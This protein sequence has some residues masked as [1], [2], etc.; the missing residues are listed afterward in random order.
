MNFYFVMLLVIALITSI[1]IFVGV[2]K[3]YIRKSAMSVPAILL[4]LGIVFTF[5]W[6][7]KTSHCGVFFVT[8]PS[9]MVV[10]SNL[11]FAL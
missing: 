3:E 10:F 1:F 8:L 2:K 6:A 5:L 4:V 7:L 9:P 11:R